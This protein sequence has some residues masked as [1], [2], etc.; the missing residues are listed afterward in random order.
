MGNKCDVSAERLGLGGN[1]LIFA[2]NSYHHHVAQVIALIALFHSFSTLCCLIKLH[3]QNNMT[4]SPRWPCERYPEISASAWQTS[5]LENAIET[6]GKC[7]LA[8][9]QR[10]DRSERQQRQRLD[11]QSSLPK[12]SSS[13]VP[14]STSATPLLTHWSR[15]ARRSH[16]S[17]R[18]TFS[19]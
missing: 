14:I 13:D 9:L 7:M 19:W 8:W 1:G 17:H 11:C 4:A 18:A 2:S 12:G 10:I 5:A 16:S 15:Y 3:Y 6:L